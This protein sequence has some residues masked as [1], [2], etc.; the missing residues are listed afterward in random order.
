MEPVGLAPSAVFRSARTGGGGITE[1]G[2]GWH[3]SAALLVQ[4]SYGYAHNVAVS[5]TFYTSQRVQESNV[6]G[7]PEVETFNQEPIWECSLMMRFEFVENWT[8][9]SYTDSA[10]GRTSDAI[11]RD[12]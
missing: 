7:N 10:S 9:K 3:R 4:P 8:R 12:L 11:E 1:G 2:G 6:T 5:V